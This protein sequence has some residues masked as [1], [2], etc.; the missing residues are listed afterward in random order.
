V[1]SVASW[2]ASWGSWAATFQED[3]ATDPIT[4]GWRVF[5]ETNL[6]YWNSTNGNLEVTWDSSQ[7]NSYFQLSTGTILGRAD[8]FSFALDLRLDDIA[9][10]IYPG[11]PG[12]FEL[13][14]GFQNWVDAQKINFF[15]GNG[16][17]SPNLAEFD[18]FAGASGIQP[19][20]WPAM[21][22]TNSRLS[23]NG[24][25]DFTVM[26]LPLGVVMRVSVAYTSSDQTMVTTIET[27]GVSVGAVHSVKISTNFTD[28]RVGTLAIASYSD[29]GQSGSGQGSILAHGVI[30]NI[31]FEVPAPPIQN[32]RQVFSNGVPG[33][34]FA[35]RSNWVY[36][37]ER[38][39]DLEGW[40]NAA[41]DVAGNATNLFIADTN[42]IAER[43]FYRVRGER[44]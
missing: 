16:L 19:T 20:L 41:S 3:F 15:R 9:G 35:S 11:K 37:L 38:S 24:I 5:G 4:H 36:A 26:S 8:D 33:V 27:N 17:N 29:S 42:G 1:L 32:L 39:M 21:W 44:P 14:F 23:Y 25:G 30:D 2:V 13:A 10:G 43:V 18:Y 31:M 6:F 12:P 34:Q 40:S 28:F 7:S 22:S